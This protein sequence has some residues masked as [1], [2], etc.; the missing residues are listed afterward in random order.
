[1]RG[2]TDLPNADIYLPDTDSG[3]STIFTSPYYE[4]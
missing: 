2:E 4:L 1:M 3:L